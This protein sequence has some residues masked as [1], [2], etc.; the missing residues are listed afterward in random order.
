MACGVY[1]QKPLL[2][3]SA[4][5]T[6]ALFS[7]YERMKVSAHISRRLSIPQKGLTQ[8]MRE[9]AK[10]GSR[11]ETLQNLRAISMNTYEENGTAILNQGIRTLSRRTCS[12][13]LFRSGPLAR[14]VPGDWRNLER[15]SWKCAC[16]SKSAKDAVVSGTA[17]QNL[18][19]VYCKLCEVK[20]RTFPSPETRKRPGRH[21]KVPARSWSRSMQPAGAR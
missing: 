21:I 10:S 19:T 9:A 4:G 6:I 20:L 18:T 14:A 2:C 12:L 5:Q 7:G 1:A 11:L 15:A 17:Q 16:K 13:Q 3:G 8:G